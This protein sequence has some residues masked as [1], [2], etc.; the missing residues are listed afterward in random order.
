VD[1]SFLPAVNASLNSLATALLVAGRILIAR[2]RVRAHRRVMTSAFVVSTVFLVLYVAHKASR[3]FENTTFN[4]VG[5][6]KVAYLAL[7][8]THVT[9]AMVVPVLAIWLIRL[10]LRDERARHRRLA[11]IAWPIWMYVSIT[12]VTIYL[13]LYPFNPPPIATGSG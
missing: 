11:R 2:G 5:A 1:L 12:G 9:L 4:A 8:F 7:L 13:L 3:G 6:F 10:G